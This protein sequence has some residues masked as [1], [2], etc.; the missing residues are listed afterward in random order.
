MYGILKSHDD[1]AATKRLKIHDSKYKNEVYLVATKITINVPHSTIMQN[2]K[3]IMF[4][5]NV[6]MYVYL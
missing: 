3:M 6:N 5:F 4:S 2:I 1:I